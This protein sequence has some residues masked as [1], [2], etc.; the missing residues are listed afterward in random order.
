MVLCSAYFKH[1]VKLVFLLF[2]V[3][4]L[5]LP[6]SYQGSFVVSP[7]KLCV[8]FKIPRGLERWAGRVSPPR[9]DNKLSPDRLL[10]S[11][12]LDNGLN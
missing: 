4:D 2:V 10:V 8:S 9:L 6:T 5:T 12:T 1:Q 3:E 11:L 7:G